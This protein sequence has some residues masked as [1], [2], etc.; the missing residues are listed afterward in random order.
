[1]HRWTAQP[2]VADLNTQSRVV[3]RRIGAPR[4]D[5]AHHPR[6]NDCAETGWSGSAMA[7][8]LAI[9]GRRRFWA[10][11]RRQ[12][13][14]PKKPPSRRP[15]FHT[16]L[17]Y[18]RTATRSVSR[19]SEF[20]VS[21]GL[22]KRDRVAQLVEESFGHFFGLAG[23]PANLSEQRLLLGVE[24]LRNDQL[25]HDV[26]VAAAT[27]SHVQHALSPQP[28]GL[29]VLGPGRDGD[30]H[31]PLQCRDLDPVAE[32][33]LDHVDAKLVHDVLLVAGKLG[34]RLDPQHDVQI[35]RR[36]AP[37]AGLAL[38]AEP[39]LRPRVDAGRNPHDQPLGLLQPSL[40]AA[41]GTR[42]LEDPAGPA[43]RR[44]AGGRHDL[45][46]E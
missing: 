8:A 38:A 34:M 4:E 27:A 16:P 43:A 31:R 13:G 30:L 21:R 32:R 5:E 9:A 41:L 37:Y 29:P 40:P 17:R 36:T 22:I 15:T 1:M 19:V 10:A 42:V 24:I 23:Q 14:G 20:S 7:K 26:L 25:D 44:A 45:A 35:T 39:D 33:R 3:H 46:E 11:V 12:Q 28:E 18:A 2:G 6:L